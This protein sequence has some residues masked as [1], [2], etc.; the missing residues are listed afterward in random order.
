MV[1]WQINGDLADHPYPLMVVGNN[2]LVS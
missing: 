1:A 2:A